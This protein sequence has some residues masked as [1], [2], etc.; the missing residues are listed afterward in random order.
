MSRATT[1]NAGGGTFDVA[2]GTTLTQN[3][4]IDGSDGLTKTGAGTLVL[5]G[6]NTYQGGTTIN[7]GVLAISAVTNLGGC[8]RVASR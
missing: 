1:L 2:T 8:Q 6:T 7:A 4:G 5:G 3:G